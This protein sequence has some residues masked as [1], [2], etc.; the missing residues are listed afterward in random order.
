MYGCMYAE[1]TGADPMTCRDRCEG[2]AV[3]FCLPELKQFWICDHLYPDTLE[4]TQTVPFS[5]K[6]IKMLFCPSWWM[7]V[8]FFVFF[9]TVIW[10]ETTWPSSPRQTSLDWNTSESC[11][12]Q[13][14]S[15]LKNSVG[16]KTAFTAAVCLK[17]YSKNKQEIKV[18]SLFQISTETVFF[19]FL[20]F[21]KSTHLRTVPHVFLLFFTSGIIWDYTEHV[22]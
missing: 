3:T 13:T 2:T 5:F 22:L 11:K 7:S 4:S 10:M 6:M 21:I 8:F 19:S 16:I 18:L 15:H 14:H 17:K 20:R 12:S 1:W 9:L